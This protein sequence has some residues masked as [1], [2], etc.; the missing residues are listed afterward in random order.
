[1]NLAAGQPARADALRAALET[2]LRAERRGPA[3]RATVPPELLE[4]LGAL[5]YVSPGAG[6]GDT[7]RAPIPGPIG[8]YKLVN[9]LMREGLTALRERRFAVSVDRLEGLVGAASTASR[10]TITSAARW[11]GSNAT[12]RP[13]P[14]RTR[15]RAAAGLGAAHLALADAQIAVGDLDAALAAFCRGQAAAP[16]HPEPTNARPPCG[17]GGAACRPRS[18][19]MR[20]RSRCCRRTR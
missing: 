2:R 7:P 6:R 4:Q 15:R 17:A 18:P 19:P 11:P 16:K 9:R 1:M 5:G 3:E 8:E 14:F 13:R 12:A 20:K 10:F